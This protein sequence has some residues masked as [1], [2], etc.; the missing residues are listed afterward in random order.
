[1]VKKKYSA[2]TNI[3]FYGKIFVL[4]VIIIYYFIYPSKVIGND[5]VINIVKN[6]VINGKL[7]PTFKANGVFTNRVVKY[8]NR[9]FTVRIDYKIEL[10]RKRRFWFDSLESQKRLSYQMNFVPLEKRYLCVKYQDGKALESK[11]DRQQEEI[12][13]WVTQPEPPLK[14]VNTMELDQKSGYYYNIEV[15]VATLT[16]ENIEHL[17]QWLDEFDEEEE[18]KSTFTETT[19]K[20]AA[21]LLSSR[22]RKNKTFRSEIFHIYN[23]PKLYMD[24]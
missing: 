7:A 20:V 3:G 23:L 22:N 5:E 10:W 2:K 24:K 16:T 21:D 15:I 11:L 13:K 8:L 18:D 6:E 1:M 17:Q 4:S 14:L 19:L 12:I 9:G